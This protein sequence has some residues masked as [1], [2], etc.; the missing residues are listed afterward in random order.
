MKTI[1]LFLDINNNKLYTEKELRKLAPDAPESMNLVDL[2]FKINAEREYYHI[3]DCRVNIVNSYTLK[4]LWNMPTKVV[5]I[6]TL[7]KMTDISIT[8]TSSNVSKIVSAS[9]TR[10][11]THDHRQHFRSLLKNASDA[12]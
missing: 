3:I 8:M 11:T 12:L 6:V 4:L 2:M 9:K 1:T 7:T 5:W 10:S